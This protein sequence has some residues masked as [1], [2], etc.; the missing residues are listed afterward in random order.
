MRFVTLTT[1]TATTTT[2][3]ATTAVVVA[4]VAVVVA[5]LSFSLFELTKSTNLPH[6]KLISS[7]CSDGNCCSNLSVIFSRMRKMLLG[8]I[9]LLFLWWLAVV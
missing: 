1:A 5:E 9:A 4:V 7:S 8:S 3:T 2:T 6:K